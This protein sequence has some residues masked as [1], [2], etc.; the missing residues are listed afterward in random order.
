MRKG[1][2]KLDSIKPSV[3]SCD[4]VTGWKVVSL[5]KIHAHA[6]VV[7][8]KSV[9]YV[10]RSQPS[11]RRRSC[12]DGLQ[13]MKDP[14]WADMRQVPENSE[15]MGWVLLCNA[16][17]GERDNSHCG[18]RGGATNL[19]RPCPKFEF[20]SHMKYNPTFWYPNPLF[21]YSA[22]K[23]ARCLCAMPVLFSQRAE[24]PHLNTVV[25]DV[26]VRQI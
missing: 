7:A 5:D 23:A 21:P 26:V 2:D 12:A 22:I 15:R 16:D 4:E 18:L 11:A 13:L 1:Q 9:K 25:G 6:A 17:F 14:T 3:I 8:L 20:M 24:T 19:L 10:M